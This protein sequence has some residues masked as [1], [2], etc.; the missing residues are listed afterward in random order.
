MTPERWRQ[1]EAIF[2][3]ALD[4]DVSAREAYLDQTCAGDP[5]LRR[6]VDSLLSAHQP[7]DQF[8]ESSALKHAARDLAG[9]MPRLSAGD[10]LGGYELIDQIGAGGMGEVWRA[11]DPPLRRHVAIK[12]LSS[13]YSRDPDRLRRFEQ[14]AQAAG[15]LNHP[16]VLAIYAVGEAGTLALPRHRVARRRNT[17]PSTPSG[18]YPGR[19]SH[20][21]WRPNRAGSCRGPHQ[22]HRPPRSQTREHLHHHRWSREDS[23]LRS[24]QA[25]AVGPGTSGCR[26]RL[27]RVSHLGTPAYMSPEQVRGQAADHRSDIFSLG[28]VLYRCCPVDIPFSRARASRR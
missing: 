16:N 11:L 7:D 1:I 2:Q 19:Q 21:I 3:A 23:G 4:R 6:E 26:P 15:M 5:E 25:G 8:L 18:A 20:R 27:P 10:R 28:A 9:D 24:R 13:Q 22:R 14:E 12:V 17:P